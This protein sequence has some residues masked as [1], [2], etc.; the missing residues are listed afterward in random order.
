MYEIFNL[1]LRKAL[2]IDSKIS[3]I[4][5]KTDFVDTGNLLNA[6]SFQTLCSRRKSYFYY[7]VRGG[8][9]FHPAAF[10]VCDT[11]LDFLLRGGA[12][13]LIQSESLSKGP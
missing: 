1:L 7:C 13:E 10:D 12:S 6:N 2:V 4:W 8:W 11:P 5:Y 9:D 3:L